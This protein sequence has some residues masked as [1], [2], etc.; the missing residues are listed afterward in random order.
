MTDF[1][2][3]MLQMYSLILTQVVRLLPAHREHVTVGVVELAGPLLHTLLPVAIVPGIHKVSQ[4]LLIV[5]ISAG[6]KMT[7][8]CNFVVSVK[9]I[10]L[11]IY[12]STLLRRGG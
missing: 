4:E 11:N 8:R 6:N 12:G 9:A 2:F 7:W 3:V 1:R 10:A 5:E